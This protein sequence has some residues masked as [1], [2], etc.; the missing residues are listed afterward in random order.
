[1]KFGIHVLYGH[2]ILTFWLL[3]K[4]LRKKK[5]PP[6]PH[7]LEFFLAF[8]Y[9]FQSFNCHRLMKLGIC[10]PYG[11][12]YLTF[13]LLLKN[14]KI[15]SPPPQLRI[16]FGFLRF[17]FQSFNCCRLMKLG[18]YMYSLWP[19]AFDVFIITDKFEK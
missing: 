13:W 14:S 12:G 11:P 18:I 1:M 6:P 2:S 15:N 9:F 8:P 10:I 19:W 3:L 16:F 17:F 7:N 4:N 5:F